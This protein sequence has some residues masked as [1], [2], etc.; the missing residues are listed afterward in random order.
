MRPRRIVD[1]DS[2]STLD[3][4]GKGELSHESILAM[5]APAEMAPA[6]LRAYEELQCYTLT[7]GGGEFIH[8]PRSAARRRSAR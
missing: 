6:E 7:L 1:F 3:A 4:P 5:T 2:N 8:F